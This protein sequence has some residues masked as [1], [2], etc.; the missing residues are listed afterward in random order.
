MDAHLS[1]HKL[2]DVV[3]MGLRAAVGVVFIVHGSGK[4]NPGFLGFMEMLGLPPE[5][6]IPIALAETVPGILL[7]I[8]VFTRLSA[9]LLSI[10]ML[11][12][13]F[14]V[15]QAGSLTGERGFELDLILLAACLVVMVAGPGRISISHVIKKMPR[16]LH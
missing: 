14:Y 16:C 8:G 5:M 4:F 15:K 11:G 7:L 12:A 6:Q 1:Q 9:S 13:I 10:V 3:N 2:H